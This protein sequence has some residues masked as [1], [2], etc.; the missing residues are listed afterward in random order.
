[1][2]R[3]KDLEEEPFNENWPGRASFDL[4]DERTVP[5]LF[6]RKKSDFQVRYEQQKFPYTMQPDF[7]RKGSECDDDDEESKRVSLQREN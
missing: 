1:M 7:E 4:E 6:S 3:W 2:E 5:E